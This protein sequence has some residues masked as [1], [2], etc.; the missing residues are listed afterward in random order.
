MNDLSIACAPATSANLFL[1]FDILGMALEGVYD[2]VQLKRS[3]ET[4]SIRLTIHNS[5][6]VLPQ[7]IEKNTATV[8][9]LAMM[10]DY[11][12]QGG[13][14][15]DLYKGIACASGMGGSAA[16]A[17]AAVVAY[18]ALLDQEITTEQL[19]QYALEGEAVASGGRHLDNVLPALVGG[20]S[21]VTSGQNWMPLPFDR[22]YGVVLHPEIQ[23]ATTDA[24]KLLPKQ[25]DLS[26]HVNQSAALAGMV[27]YL[28]QSNWR[29]ACALWQN[30]LIEHARASLWPYYPAIKQAALD[31]GALGVCISGSGPSILAL[32]DEA[33]L[34]PQ[35]SQAMQ[36][37]CEVESQVH[38]SV[39]PAPGA[40]VE[41]VR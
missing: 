9:L 17:V 13:L 6:T 14:E 37:A 8:A 33:E 19:L 25:I 10:Q 3:D 40:W 34:L 20:L 2:R 16:S 27:A 7:A 15:L 4:D 32:C 35:V 36:A 31:Q 1:G 5:D 29:S 21:L 38:Q 24:R 28:C 26:D 12:C 22:A 41:E 23:V 18:R 39:L 30:S 11:P